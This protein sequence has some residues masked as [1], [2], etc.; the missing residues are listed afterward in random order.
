MISALYRDVIVLALCFGLAATAEASPV[1]FGQVGPHGSWAYGIG[2][3]DSPS[4]DHMQFTVLNG[5]LNQFDLPIGITNLDVTGWQ[6]TF[7]DG[8]LLVVDG[9]ASG[10]V[11]FQFIFAGVPVDGAVLAW[12]TFSGND[13]KSNGIFTISPSGG[14]TY[15][16]PSGL[17][18]GRLT[19]TPGAAAA[20][21]VAGL[22]GLRRRR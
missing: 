8:S 21:G 9:P 13:L 11:N 14:W 4:F 17:P 2:N 1:G 3:T 7:N 16:E 6:Q 15:S 5:S 20:L 10:L 12:Q 18:T 19:P 22:F